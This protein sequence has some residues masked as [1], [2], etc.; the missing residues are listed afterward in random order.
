MPPLGFGAEFGAAPYGAEDVEQRLAA[1]EERVAQLSH[2][3]GAELRPDLSGGALTYETGYGAQEAAALS[4][5][6]AK[7]AAD[8]KQAKDNKDIEKMNEG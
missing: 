4:E 3:I 8:A 7:E 2:F 1:L 6:L 5:Q